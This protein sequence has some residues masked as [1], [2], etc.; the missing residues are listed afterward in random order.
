MTASQKKT[1]APDAADKGKISGGKRLSDIDQTKNDATGKASDVGRQL[2]FAGIATVWLLR[3]ETGVQPFGHILLIALI[4]LASALFSDFLQYACN[5]YVWRKFYNEQFDRHKTDDALVDIPAAIS[6]RTYLF[7]T[8]KI[9][10]LLVGYVFLL[11]GAI[12]KLR[13]F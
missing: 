1:C 2:A 5:S 13:I 3:D 9:W 11:V 7:F 6:S 12:I 4:L 10:L 8:I